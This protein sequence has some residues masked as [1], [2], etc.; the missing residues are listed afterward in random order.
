MKHGYNLNTIKG[1]GY[2][3][4][5]ISMA[6]L[7]KGQSPQEIYE[8]LEFF[9]KKLQSYSSDVIFLYTGGLYFNSEELTHTKRVKSNAQMLEHSAALR[10]LI[11]KK[12]QFIPGAFHYL[13][14]DYVILNSPEF[15]KYF[16]L[17]KNRTEN[18]DKL[19]KA[20]KKDIGTRTPNEANIN[21]ILEE[22]VV[23]QLIREKK[24]EFPK[25]LVNNESWRLIVYPGSYIET[26]YYQWKHKLLPQNKKVNTYSGTQFDFEKKIL[27]VFDDIKS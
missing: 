8:I 24:V 4:I 14:I 13:P 22:T 17:L 20:L 6:R 11:Q 21:F 7:S 18:D 16:N 15:S 3:I 23:T 2:L 12:K 27:N 9:S 10:K 1:E 25:T 19:K 26:D 5:P